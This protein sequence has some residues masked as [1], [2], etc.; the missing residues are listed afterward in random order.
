MSDIFLSYVLDD[1]DKAQRLHDAFKQQGWTVWF[2]PVRLY[3][4]DATEEVDRE[5]KGAKVIVAL[6]SRRA[7]R[8]S[9]FVRESLNRMSSALPVFVRLDWRVPSST[10]APAR[11][12]NLSD[13]DGSES[14]AG[15]QDL[16]SHLH[17][18]ISNSAHMA[19]PP[20]SIEELSLSEIQE[21]ARRGIKDAGLSRPTDDARFKG[22]FIS[23][24][25][26][27]AAAYAGRL[28][29]RLAARFGREKVFMD[30]ANIGL[31]ED[32]YEVVTSASESCAVMLALI[33]PR[34]L[35]GAGGQSDLDDYVR[36]EVATAL[37]RKILVIPIL[38]QGASMP[39]SQDLPEDL[40][41][42]A[43]RNALVLSDD[44]RWER[45]VE[46]LMKTLEGLLKD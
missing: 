40:S 36:L 21:S 27:E 14:H 33:S 5:I 1:L 12:F 11:V 3:I 10:L 16:L 38:I 7:V 34:W 28:Y 24:R 42:L 44:A 43:R 15:L 29:D 19:A 18:L 32:F 46:D 45:D 22:V 4:N 39:A 25:R 8:A 9:S 35:R 2:D 23:Y 13:W 41:P 31:G 20:A 17:A 26:N 37:R 30:T 6:W